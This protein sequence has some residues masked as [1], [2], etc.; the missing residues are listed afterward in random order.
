MQLFIDFLP[1]VAF[2]IAYWLADIKTAIAVIMVA[3]SLQVAITWVVKRTV[4]KMLLAS[5]ALVVV[6]GA[7]SLA[8]DNDL[9]FKWKPTVLNWAFAAVFLVS[10]Y[11]GNKPMVQRL[12]ESIAKGEINLLPRDWQRLNLMWAGFFLLSGAANLFVAYNFPEGVWVNFKLFGLLGMT[13]V[14]VML[15]ALWLSRRSLPADTETPAEDR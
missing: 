4:S 1:I 15:Q 11:A 12:L 6:L 7:I 2:V 3:M 14:F 10:R 9:V 5:A 13:L 8:I